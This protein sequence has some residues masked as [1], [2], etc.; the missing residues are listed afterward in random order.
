ML[1]HDNRPPLV[2]G[3]VLGQQQNPTRND[4]GK[5]IENDFVAVREAVYL[6]VTNVNLGTP[7]W[8]QRTDS[9]LRPFRVPKTYA[10]FS[11]VPE[12]GTVVLA[13]MGLTG[14]GIAGRSRR[15]AHI[16]KGAAK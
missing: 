10:V 11:V 6:D 16:R 5:D 9:Q 12:P 4:I 7:A 8:L 13:G 14:L 2:G 3:K 15:P 1:A